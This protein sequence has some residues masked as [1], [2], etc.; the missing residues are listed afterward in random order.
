MPGGLGK[1]KK[2][3]VLA[4]KRFDEELKQL[5]ADFYGE[6]LVL[7]MVSRRSGD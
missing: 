7:D 6:S 3:A 1:T 5:G 2:I 4:D